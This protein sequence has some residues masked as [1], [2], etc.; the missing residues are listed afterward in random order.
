MELAMMNL[1][2]SSG[3]T[4]FIHRAWKG[5][6]RTYFSLEIASFGGEVH[7]YIWCWKNYRNVVEQAMYSQYPEIEL[8]EAEDYASKFQ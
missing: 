2:T 7:F 5:Q 1:S 3:E 8:V 6:I 4:T